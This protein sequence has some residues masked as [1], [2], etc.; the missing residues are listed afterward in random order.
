MPAHHTVQSY[1]GLLDAG[2]LSENDRVELLEGVIVAM[3]PQNPRLAAG[4]SRAM[5]AFIAAV[6]T[7]AA[8]R[9]QLSLPLGERSVPE[10]DVAIVPGRTADYDTAHPTTALLIVEVADSSLVQDRLTKAAIYAAAGVPEYWI[11]NLR[12]DRVEVF[13]TPDPAAR[14]YTSSGVAG[15]GERLE[16]VALPGVSVVV[17]DLLPGR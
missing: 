15:R 7:R 3:A 16:P 1:F 6:G 12:D 4:V 2:I 8:V 17:A 5:D 14:A 10:P 11:V 9:V 13:R